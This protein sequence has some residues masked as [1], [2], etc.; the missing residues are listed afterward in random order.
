MINVFLKWPKQ[1]L[2]SKGITAPNMKY[3]LVQENKTQPNWDQDI[4]ERT[5]FS[6]VYLL[7]IFN[8]TTCSICVHW[9]VIIFCL[10]SW[11]LF[12]S[13]LLIFLFCWLMKFLLIWSYPGCG[14]GEEEYKIRRKKEWKECSRGV[15]VDHSKLHIYLQRKKNCRD[16]NSE[17]YTLS[18]VW[19]L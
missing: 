7:G 16:E 11:F 19:L 18:Q 4:M 15:D 13:F 12:S 6:P 10:L 1:D 2:F 8:F 9:F 17:N 5:I 14:I 3:N